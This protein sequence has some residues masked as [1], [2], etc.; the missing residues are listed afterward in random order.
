MTL[1]LS[2]LISDSV[3]DFSIFWNK[4]F[5]NHHDEHHHGEGGLAMMLPLVLLAFGA[6]GAGF[7]PFGKFVSA[8]GLPHEAKIELSFSALPVFIGIAGIAIAYLF[9]K[10]ESERAGKFA[11][12]LNVFYK[13]AFR[14]FYVDEI[15][16]FIT[17]KILFNV[18]GKTAAWFDR[19]IIDG[20]VNLLGNGTAIVS[21]KIKKIQSGSVQQ[22][23]L[24]FLLAVLTIASLFIYIWKS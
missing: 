23:A 6:I 4:G 12:A 20:S 10:N 19:T 5:N 7:I 16:L 22:Y 1:L 2:A 17:Q 9:Y 11:S 3:F 21:E 13:A 15:Y 24:Y 14:K 18:I 8:N